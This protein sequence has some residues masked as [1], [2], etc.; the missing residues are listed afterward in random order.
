ML[1][2]LSVLIE[3]QALDSALDAAHKRLADFPAAEKLSTEHVATAT[4]ALE[5][6]RTAFNNSAAARKLVEKDVAG[7]DLR[8]ARFEEHK[9]AVKTNEQ[10]HALQHEM[11]MGKQE[12]AELEERV[13]VLMLEADE[14]AAGV[15][16]AEG[17]LATAN[18]AMTAMTAEHAKDRDVLDAEIARLQAER[19]AKTPGVDKPTLAKYEQLLKGRRGVA[20]AE[21]TGGRCTACHMGLRP[22]VQAQVKR[23]DALNTCE[24]CQRILYFV[25]P[26]P[27]EAPPAPEAGQ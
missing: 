17:R 15:K 9:A 7:V 18:K 3:L 25:P 4:A 16:E 21:M 23:N 6:A 27:A 26:P 8:L 1:A 2:A 19:A 10:F 14:L 5:A 22:A 12:K 11:E 20:I 13:L 24:S